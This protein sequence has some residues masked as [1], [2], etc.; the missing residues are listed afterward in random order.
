MPA[1]YGIGDHHLFVVDFIAS[2]LIGL[3]LKEIMQP[4]AKC[5]NCNIPR[6]VK[7]YNKRLE[8]KNLCHCLLER[9]GK[10]H[11]SDLP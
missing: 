3:A 10:V 5:L 6:V 4:Q 8:E 2:P 11:D 9:V 7:S 1:G